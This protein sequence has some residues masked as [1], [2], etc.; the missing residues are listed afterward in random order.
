[1]PE[2][3]VR[4]QDMI[5]PIINNAAVYTGD[6]R[7]WMTFLEC[8]GNSGI[9]DIVFVDFDQ[10][11][12]NNRLLRGLKP[13]VSAVDIHA[14][15]ALGCGEPSPLS[16]VSSKIGYSP[17]HTKSAL[18]RLVALGFVEKYD[19]GYLMLNCFHSVVKSIIAIEVKR[20]NWT[21]GLYQ[22]RRYLRFANKSFLVLD[23]VYTNRISPHIGKIGTQHIG[24]GFVN[25][26]D[27]TVTILSHPEW[28]PALSGADHALIG[29]RLWSLTMSAGICRFAVQHE[30]V[31][32]K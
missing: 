25:A 8:V 16:T 19:D 22:A 3:F 31:L 27:Y 15:L 12:I 1:M 28:R 7:P 6:V 26:S 17:S 5:E 9:A 14:L 21:R 10:D 2:R 18:S 29:E 24:L 30:P 32:L 4:E 23:K 20:E 13:L 11:A